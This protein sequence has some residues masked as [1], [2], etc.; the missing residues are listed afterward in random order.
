[1]WKKRKNGQILTEELRTET[2]SPVT[3]YIATDREVLPLFSMYKLNSVLC[4]WW[5]KKVRIA[6]IMYR[7]IGDQL[8]SFAFSP[9]GKTIVFYRFS[10]FIYLISHINIC[11]IYKY[12]FI[13]Q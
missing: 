12:N 8:I 5:L 3:G 13:Y 10:I 4:K 7:V 9:E 6:S 2:I 1:M 11:P